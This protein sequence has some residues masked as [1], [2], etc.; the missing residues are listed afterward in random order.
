MP[1]RRNLVGFI[2]AVP[3]VKLESNQPSFRMKTLDTPFPFV[4][5]SVGEPFPS[6]RRIYHTL[7]YIRPIFSL[8]FQ[9][10]ATLREGRLFCLCRTGEIHRFVSLD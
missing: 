4:F 2:V 5:T 9:R 3:V 10:H 8:I 7:R 1:D 6:P